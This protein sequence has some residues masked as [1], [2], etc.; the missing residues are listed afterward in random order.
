MVLVPKPRP[1]T[2]EPVRRQK[3]FQK[4]KRVPRKSH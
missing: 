2:V 1:K 4:R 3:P